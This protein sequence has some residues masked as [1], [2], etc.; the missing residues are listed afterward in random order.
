MHYFYPLDCQIQEYDWGSKTSLN[1]LFGIKNI[2]NKPQAEVWMGTHPNGC[3]TIIVNDEKTPLSTFIQKQSI[4]ALGEKVV[5]RFDGLP[6]LFKILCADKALSVQVH[7]NKT[8]A[9]QGFNKEQNSGKVALD[10]AK[11]NY[12]DPNHKPELVYALTPFQAMNGF[13]QF[14]EI[15]T[16]LSRLDIHKLNR[17][18]EEFEANLTHDG[19]RLLFEAILYTKGAEKQT[20][21]SGLLNHAKKHRDIEPFNLVLTLAQQYPDDIGLFSPLFLNTITL[22]PGEAMFLRACTPHAYISGS[23]LEIM[24][25]SDNVLRAGLT[26]KHVDVSELTRC[27]EFYPQCKS[28]LRST[29]NKNLNAQHYAIPVDDFSFSVYS[30]SQINQLETDS[31]EIIIA[32]DSPITLSHSNGESVT[33]NQGEPVFVAA[34]VQQYAVSC[35]GTFARAYCSLN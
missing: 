13:R 28:T 26:S 2:K 18:L 1:Q 27:V 11:R 21:I 14:D 17:M 15:L 30:S 4:F 31:A 3:S 16:L 20:M 23:A 34:A 12:K 9:E 22:K 5:K 32:L 10:S 35:S 8:Q 7:P 29:P 19:L 25:N 24:A 6:F 33:L